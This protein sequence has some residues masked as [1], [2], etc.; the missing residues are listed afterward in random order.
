MTT[1]TG[2]MKKAQAAFASGNLKNSE[3]LCRKL[4][5][6][7]Q[8]QLPVR[9]LLAQ[10]LIKQNRLEEAADFAIEAAEID[11]SNIGLQTTTGDLLERLKKYDEAFPFYQR[12]LAS[13]PENSAH[14]RKLLSNMHKSAMSA[15]GLQSQDPQSIVLTL[16]SIQDIPDA[17]LQ[18]ASKALKA[19]PDDDN[20]VALIGEIFLDAEQTEAA[21]LCFERVLD[22]RPAVWSAHHNWL[23]LKHYAEEYEQI[24]DYYRRHET[25]ISNNALCLRVVA[26]AYEALG[27]DQ[28]ALSFIQMAMALK[29]DSAEHF[30]VRGRLLLH[31]GRFEESLPDLE[32]AMQLDPDE[33]S[34]GNNRRIAHQGLGMVSEAGADEFYR[35][36]V[37][38]LSPS[39]DFKVPLWKDQSLSG[40]R[41]FIWSDQGIGDVF[42][43]GPLIYELP[44][45]CTPIIMGQPKT[46]EFLREA[47]PDAE[48][49]PY[50][51]QLV[52]KRLKRKINHTSGSIT[53]SEARASNME[54]YKTF[55]KIEENFDFQIPLGMLYTNLRPNLDSFSQKTKPF[56]LPSPVIKRFANLDILSDPDCVRVGI[57]WGSST[58]SPK[59]DRIYLTPEELLPVFSLPGFQFF[60]FQYTIGETEVAELRDKFEIPLL[61]APGLD[62]FNDMLGTAAF[63][64]CMDLFIGPSSTSSDIAGSMGVRSYRFHAAQSTINLGQ[65]YVPW[66]ADQKSVCIPSDGAARDLIPNMKDWLLANKS[67]RGKYREL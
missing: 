27:D 56:V 54:E 60:S 13:Q 51:K 30:G 47:F 32:Q 67:H 6:D 31:L 66:Y 33:P 61:H 36:Q 24:V 35:F 43:F 57:A 53:G 65:P 12:A 41:L 19:F 58:Q 7:R 8:V 48:L 34:H 55:E 64:S 3:K 11:Q 9:A 10:T 2:L 16:N 63:A 26:A 21:V 44:D 1:S 40:K 49:R 17:L 59:E 37:G 52:K 23:K 20:L 25:T 62:L 4:L 28:T 42:K 22:S 39:Y 46:E 38:D 29:P 15:A 18:L 45:D 14:W 50:A 5:R